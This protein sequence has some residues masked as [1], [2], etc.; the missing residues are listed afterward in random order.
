M[1]ERGKFAS[2]DCACITSLNFLQTFFSANF[3]LQLYNVPFSS[4]SAILVDRMDYLIIGAKDGSIKVHLNAC[5][6]I[7]VRV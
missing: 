3:L 2:I 1:I 6:V 5:M 7:S 4:C